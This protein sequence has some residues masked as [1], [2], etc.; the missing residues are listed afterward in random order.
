MITVTNFGE[1]KKHAFDIYDMI[2]D[3]AKED[4]SLN[5]ESVD[6]VQYALREYFLIKL[7]EIFPVMQNGNCYSDNFIVIIPINGNFQGVT[8]Q[9]K[10][11]FEVKKHNAVISV[12]SE[13]YECIVMYEF[14]FK[15]E[16]KHEVLLTES[17]IKYILDKIKESD[18]LLINSN[19]KDKL[20][21]KLEDKKPL[22]KPSEIINVKIPSKSIKVIDDLFK[23]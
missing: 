5:D 21:K 19:L 22:P 20:S 15:L 2:F 17:E 8:R 10:F 12:Y 18:G 3:L 14:E 11:D 13:H 6:S 9:Y 16:R 7:Q 23:F 1:F 4:H